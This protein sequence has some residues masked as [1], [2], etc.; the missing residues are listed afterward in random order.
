MALAPLEGNATHQI[1][2]MGALG[3]GL[4]TLDELEA[5]LPMSRRAIV[6]ASGRLVERRYVDREEAGTYSLTAQGV[7]HL[8]AGLP[9][10]SGPRGP[11]TGK[12]GPNR[13]T[14]RQRAWSAMRLTG[15][16]TQADILLR[17]AVTDDG[18]AAGNLQ[19]YVHLLVR[20][21]YLAVLPTRVPGSAETSN[22]HR[23]YRVVR[24]TGERAPMYREGARAMS[25]LNTGGDFP[26]R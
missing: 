16:F 19:R 4:R 24:D 23:V 12:R 21:G 5:H 13:D 11:H 7:A 2:V 3:R 10:K 15:R 22:G 14:F 20:A 9:M 6:K 17:A 18:N 8:E 25:D 1:A 26:C